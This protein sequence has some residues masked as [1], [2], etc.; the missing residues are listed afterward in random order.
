MLDTQLFLLPQRLAFRKDSKSNKQGNQNVA[1]H[2]VRSIY[3][4]R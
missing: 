2:A 4:L 1:Q 3:I